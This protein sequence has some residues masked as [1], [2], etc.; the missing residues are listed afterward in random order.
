MTRYTT[1]PPAFVVFAIAG[2]LLFI[3][4]GVLT[5]TSPTARWILIIA[6]VAFGVLGTYTLIVVQRANRYAH[7]MSDVENELTSLQSTDA[8]LRTR[9]VYTLRDPL[10]TIVGFADRMATDPD[11]DVQRR[12]AMLLEIRNSAREVEGVLADL[13]ATSDDPLA[14]HHVEGVVL[15]DHEA[16]SV[17]ATA[18]GGT[19]FSSDLQPAKA[20]ADSSQVRQILR[21]VLKAAR[22]SGCQTI[23]VKTEERTSRAVATI[24]T[25]GQL[26]PIEGIAALTGNTEASDTQNKTYVALRTIH[27]S[28]AEM[29]GS[30]GYTEVFGMSHVVIEFERAPEDVGLSE[31]N[32]VAEVAASPSSRSAAGTGFTAAV[33]LRPERPTASIRFS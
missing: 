25:H 17:I 3:L 15:L 9:M 33:D 20:W 31:S 19:Q 29:G 1:T 5:T 12:N 10:T 4:G 14:A 11:L 22:D 32:D 8:G 7:T 24:S 28:A 13:A 2:G 21:T 30:I 26:L 16:R 18:P 6:G 27:E 23:T